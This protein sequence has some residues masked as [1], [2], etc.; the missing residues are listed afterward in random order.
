MK[1]NIK[2]LTTSITILAAFTAL[3]LCSCSKSFKEY[4]NPENKNRHIIIDSDTGSDDASAIILASA[5]KDIDFLGVTVLAGNVDIE[6]SAKNALMSLEVAGRKVPVYKGAR[7]DLSGKH[8]IPF[9]VFG[10]DGMGDMDLIHPTTTAEEM[11][12]VDFILESVKKYPNEVEII[13]LGPATNIARAIMRDKETMKKV[14]MI[15]SMGTTGLGHGNA[16]P[17]AEFNVF[18]D[19]PAYKIMLD[20]KIPVTIIGFDMCRGDVEWGDK[21]LDTINN[22]G[23]VGEFI[24][25]SYAKIIEA[26]KGAN[27]SKITINCDVVATMV[28]LYPEFIE[29]SHMSY[30]SC[31]DDEGETYGEVLF[32]LKDHFYDIAQKDFDYHVRLITKVDGKNFT[33]NFLKKIKRLN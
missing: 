8:R 30:A 23:K 31:I 18:L 26:Y 9:S 15:W 19:V 2:K 10:K 11:D 25:K 32:Y 13:S 27:D 14:K 3:V 5:E 16:T 20:S 28:A 6:Q 17:V 33:P 29:E 24:S 7:S 1:Y 21:E 22:S 4:T 12:A